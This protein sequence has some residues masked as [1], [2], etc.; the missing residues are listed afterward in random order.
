M[1]GYYAPT[2]FAFEN[3]EIQDFG[4]VLD[5]TNT[6]GNIVHT[7]TGWFPFIYSTS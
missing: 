5:P 6:L 2:T 3:G 7:L 4:A 1:K